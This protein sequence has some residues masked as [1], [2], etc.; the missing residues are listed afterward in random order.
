MTHHKSGQ[1]FAPSVKQSL[2]SEHRTHEPIPDRPVL[3]SPSAARLLRYAWVRGLY[4]AI[5]VLNI[6]C[7]RR[8]GGSIL[9]F[10]RAEL[11]AW[12]RGEHVH[13]SHAR[14]TI[15]RKVKLFLRRS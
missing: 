1:P 2:G 3:T 7:Y 8:G 14:Q 6:P 5:P 9:L 13:Q 15:A 10:D 4:K 11:P 12:V